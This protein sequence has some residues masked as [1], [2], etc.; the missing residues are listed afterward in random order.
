MLV[1]INLF[2]YEYELNTSFKTKWIDINSRTFVY[3]RFVITC[4]DESHNGGIEFINSGNYFKIICWF[5][6]TVSK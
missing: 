2:K 6:F 5:Q 4:Q 1:W 3:W